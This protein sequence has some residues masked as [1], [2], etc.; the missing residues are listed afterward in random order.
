MNIVLWVLRIVLAVAFLGA[1]ATKLLQPKVKLRER[2]AWVDDFSGTMVKAIGAAEVVGAIGLLIPA[3]TPFAAAGLVIIMV[4]AVIT[5]IRRK[6][7]PMV[8][9]PLV[10]LALSAALAFGSA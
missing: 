1:G 7:G 6:E 9:P 4:G 2:M 10:L 5:H 8:F 3:L